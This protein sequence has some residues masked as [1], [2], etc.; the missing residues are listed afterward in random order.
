MIRLGKYGILSLI[1]FVL[2][3]TFTI[4]GHELAA[5]SEEA[6]YAVTLVSVF[7]FNFMMMRHWV[8]ADQK[9]GTDPWKQFIHTVFASVCFRSLEYI[10]FILLHTLLGVHYL[11]A[12]GCVMAI[13]FFIKFFYYREKVFQKKD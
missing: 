11:I 4:I 7:I 12:I 9:E 2:I 8:Y 13:W 1:S 6:A 10:T 5:L 3:Y